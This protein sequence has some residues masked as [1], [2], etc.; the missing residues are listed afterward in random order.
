M[1]SDHIYPVPS[2]PLLPYPPTHSPLTT[3]SLLYFLNSTE[4]MGSRLYV[5]G[6]GVMPWII[7]GLRLYPCRKLTGD[8]QQPSAG[9]LQEPLL[10]LC[11]TW[12]WPDF[13]QVLCV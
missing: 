1:G 12:G 4:S 11:Y 8:P 13:V 7:G 2:L 6:Y 3:Y 5:C 9:W 10:P